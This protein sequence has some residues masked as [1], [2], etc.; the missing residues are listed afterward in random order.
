MSDP[1]DDDEPS[2]ARLPRRVGGLS[3]LELS[4]VAGRALARM[5]LPVVAKLPTVVA[6]ARVDLF[7]TPIGVRPVLPSIRPRLLQ[8]PALVAPGPQ[9]MARASETLAKAGWFFDPDTPFAD[10]RDAAAAI[11]AARSAEAD[12]LMSDH[13]ERRSGEIEARLA[14]SF[15]GR[16]GVL[17]PAFA[18]HGRGEFALSVL[19]FLSQADGLSAELRGGHFFLR[20]PGRRG[21][22]KK[23]R[24]TARYV[25]LHDKGGFDRVRLAA[26]EIELPIA[27]HKGERAP[28]DRSLN[29]HAVLHGE[30]SD[31]GTKINSLK[32]LSLLN[33]VAFGAGARGDGSEGGAA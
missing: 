18:A 16:S 6:T 17:A 13:F 25:L 21:G 1:A 23:K 20:E 7:R 24:Q 2:P 9:E 28:G 15:P 31:Y 26:L 4:E 10:F 12:E 14:E 5:K 30:A 11:D 29:R 32:A 22:P 33:Y 8:L 27:A 19:A 3:P